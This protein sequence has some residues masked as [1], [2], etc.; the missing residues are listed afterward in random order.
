MAWPVPLSK[1][2]VLDNGG[3]TLSLPARNSLQTPTNA[4]PSGTPIAE[5]LPP[6]FAQSEFETI[7]R[8]QRPIPSHGLKMPHAHSLRTPRLDA[9]WQFA[10]SG[11]VSYLELDDHELQTAQE[12][13]AEPRSSE[14]GVFRGTAI[15]GVAV[16]GSVFYAFPAIAVTSGIYSPLSLAIACLLLFPFRPILLELGRSARFNGANYAYLLHFGGKAF[17]VVGAAATLFDALSTAVVSAAT[18]AAYLL[19][20]INHVPL[21]PLA[22]AF[23]ILLALTLV[24]FISMRESSSLAVVFATI[25]MTTMAMLLIA[26]MVFW[27]RH[28]TQIIA[29]NWALRPSG[30]ASTAKAIFNGVCIG[31]LSVTGFESSPAYIEDIR[32][33][34]YKRILSNLLW[35]AAALDAPL[36]LVVF[37]IL[38]Q[39]QILSGANILSVLAEH[40]A[41]RWL[42]IITVVD[43]MLVL[44]GGVLTGIF[45]VCGLIE[46][47]SRDNVLPRVFLRKT[48]ITK[49]PIASLG[50]FITVT[51]ALYASCGFSLS[52]A[53]SLFSMAFLTV[54]GLYVL[55]FFF[56]RTMKWRLVRGPRTSMWTGT[57]CAIVIITVLV[58]NIVP[59]PKIF[60]IFLAYIFGV[61]ALFMVPMFELPALRAFMHFHDQTPALHRLKLEHPVLRRIKHLQRAPSILW[62]KTDDL[63]RLLKACIHIQGENP[64]SRLI[65]VHA[66]EAM[67]H[68]PSELEANSKI[69]DEAFPAMTIDLVFL[70]GI[71]TPVVRFIIHFPI[72]FTESCGDSLRRPSVKS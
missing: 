11:S 30:S 64:T 44:S 57:F 43:A 37:A 52:T 70:K 39:S 19:G 34:G 69:L 7:I 31:F 18:A 16:W 17:A 41:G 42:R 1:R 48:S 25:H 6:T 66:Y 13:Y 61:T 9:D 55:S 72:L 65:W 47:L 71:F 46:R 35:G 26:S 27:A 62:T 67:E 38:P 32:P 33:Q 2:S 5:L 12:K 29:A 23:F 24:A 53:S 49:A 21:P 10:G 20:E 60:G 51:A 68:I 36:M 3:A 59:N 54:M 40:V 15:A 50:F 63:H 45:T 28:G 14:M 56:L 8:R 22:V 4:T 58:G